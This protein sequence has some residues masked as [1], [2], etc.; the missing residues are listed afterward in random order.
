M[1]G[2]LDGRIAIIT[3]A[4]RGIGRA[5][6]LRFAAEGARLVLASR[7]KSQLE[8]VAREIGRADDTAIIA[9][10]LSQE[11]GSRQAVLAANDRFG[12]LHILVNNAAIY[13]PVKPIEEITQQE[14]DEVLAANLRSAFLMT[15]TAL[16]LLYKSQ[17][18]A[19]VNISS[20]AAKAAIPWGAPYAASKA[21]LLSLTRT[22]AAEGAR[23]GLRCNA[24]LPGP[25]PETEMSQELGRKLAGRAG[26]DAA[27]MFTEF[28]GGIL[29]GR[30]QTVDEIAAAALYLASDQSSAITGQALNVDGG[31]LFC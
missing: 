23:K 16:P 6:A 18:S 30:P 4:G 3:G 26:R 12:A 31:M 5:I 15:R 29:Q 9:A 11:S 21:A 7:T 10:D 22:T 28:L 20:V 14:W 8:A 1:P 25:V 24:I 13:G 17:H 2:Q 27:E 19:I